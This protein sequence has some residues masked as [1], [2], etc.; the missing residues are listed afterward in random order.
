MNVLNRLLLKLT[1]K[2]LTEESVPEPPRRLIIVSALHR[3]AHLYQQWMQDNQPSAYQS[4][5][6]V[7][8]STRAEHLRGLDPRTTDFRY[9]YTPESFGDS[10]RDQLARL[11]NLG[12]KVGYVNLD[13]CYG[14]N[15]DER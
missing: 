7:S 9:V 2:T 8:I 13:D 15:R 1:G 6:R 4:Y 10:Q 12:A 3:P 14:V 11:F 5:H